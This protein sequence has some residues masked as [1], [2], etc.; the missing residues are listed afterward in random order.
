MPLAELFS[1]MQGNMPEKE[2]K[3]MK[4][5]NEMVDDTLPSTD[6]LQSAKSKRRETADKVTD[7]LANKG[8]PTVG[9]VAGA[10]TDLTADMIP[11][12]REAYEEQMA[13]SMSPM[14]A[15]GKVGTA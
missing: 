11:E 7:Y 15:V 9:A 3:K 10:A 1:K 4:S 13:S 12:S 14:G 8:W 2:K 6:S 5:A